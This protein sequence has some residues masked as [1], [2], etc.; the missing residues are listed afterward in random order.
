MTLASKVPAGCYGVVKTRGFLGWLIRISTHSPYDHAF[1]FLGGGQVIEASSPQ[2][3]RIRSL[4]EYAGCQMAANTAE[5]ITTVER[6]AVI[7]QARSLVGDGYAWPDLAV[8]GLGEI[9]VHWRILL[10]LTGGRHAL[11]CSWYVAVCGLAAALTSWQCG[12]DDPS[13][14]TPAM[15][16]RRPQVRVVQN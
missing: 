12:A 5:A 8:I 15:L 16:S 3:V 4:P 10:R 9:G 1:L 7:E 11:I 13:Q 2:G 14:V 6:A